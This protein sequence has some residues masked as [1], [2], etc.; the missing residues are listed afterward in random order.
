MTQLRK[1]TDETDSTYEKFF[2][3]VSDRAKD[4]GATMSDTINASADFARLGYDIDTASKMADAALV[5]KNVGDNITDIGQASQ[6]LTST[7]QAF[8]DFGIDKCV[9]WRGC[10]DIPAEFKFNGIDT[11]NLVRGYF[12][13]FF[14]APFDIDKKAEC[15]KNNLDK[16]AEKSGNPF[17][18]PF[19][20][21]QDHLGKLHL[22]FEGAQHLSRHGTLPPQTPRCR[23]DNQG[24]RTSRRRDRGRGRF[25]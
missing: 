1:V 15:I 9:V 5:Y 14:S 4:I 25:R 22:C 24:G 18:C 6:S 17:R 7:I 8:K 19:C 20:G 21:F 12:M 10:G 13:D 2:D 16:I 3:G 11:V 23:R